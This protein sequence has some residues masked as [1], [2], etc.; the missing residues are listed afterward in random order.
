MPET[1]HLIQ[2]NEQSSPRGCSWLTAPPG[3]CLLFDKENL[4]VLVSLD[5]V[6]LP[7]SLTLFLPPTLPLHPLAA[8]SVRSR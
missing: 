6:V 3:G 4:D 2:I 7:F 1:L 5:A 8:G